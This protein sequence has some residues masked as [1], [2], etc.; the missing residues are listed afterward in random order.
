MLTKLTWQA[1]VT[2]LTLPLS[3]D[4]LVCVNAG[5]RVKYSNR[6]RDEKSRKKE[7]YVTLGEDER[8]ERVGRARGKKTCK[9]KSHLHKSSMALC[10]GEKSDGHGRDKS[11]IK[12]SCLP[13]TR[14][15][16]Q[17]VT[18]ACIVYVCGACCT[19]KNAGLHV[20]LCVYNCKCLCLLIHNV[21]SLCMWCMCASVWMSICLSA[22]P[23]I[24]IRLSHFCLW[25]LVLNFS[26]KPV[27]V[28]TVGGCSF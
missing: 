10:E 3:A 22:L 18:P 28:V 27:T 25:P 21:N 11:S 26:S 4:E 14:V 15:S 12:S 1:V 20:H 13:Q 19:V 8:S 6:W 5:R 16:K 9:S 2:R 17:H 7:I 24:C 23:N